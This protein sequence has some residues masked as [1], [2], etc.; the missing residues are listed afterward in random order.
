MSDSYRSRDASSTNVGI[1]ELRN[2]VELDLEDS[3]SYASPL[4]DH[5]RR[6]STQ[7]PMLVETSHHS[8]E[9]QESDHYYEHKH[10]YGAEKPKDL[11]TTEELM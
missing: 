10:S 7:E 4:P 2:N 6:N 11:D 5:A 8:R 1:S 9:R 3:M